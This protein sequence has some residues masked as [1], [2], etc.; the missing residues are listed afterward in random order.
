M[1]TGYLGAAGSAGGADDHTT[2]E[3]VPA[4]LPPLRDPF[5]AFALAASPT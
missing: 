1:A 4:D 3:E 2:G 5:R